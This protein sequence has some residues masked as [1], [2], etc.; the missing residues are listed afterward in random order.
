[1]K[2]FAKLLVGLVS[3]LVLAFS[4]TACDAEGT[5][6][7]TI[8]NGHSICYAFTA[9]ESKMTADTKSMHDYMCILKNEGILNFE[10]TVS[11]Y[12]AY[13]TSVL[14]IG[15]V[16]VSY[17]D[18]SYSGWDWMLYT[19]VTTIDGVPYSDDATY[20]NYNGV[21]LYKASY[22]ADGIPCV[23]G[24]SYALVYEFSTMTW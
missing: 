8:E 9:D 2:K 5:T 6:D 1:M 10:S 4:F 24:E 18:N 14:G 16:A 22:G 7:G 21:T 15:S 20:I 3:I 12:G 19:T 13:I 17:T 23:A 11:D